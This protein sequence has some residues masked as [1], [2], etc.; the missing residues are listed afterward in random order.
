MT[1]KPQ[2]LHLAPASLLRP[3]D[4]DLSVRAR[5][6][7]DDSKKQTAGP[8]A[9]F[10]HLFEMWCTRIC[11][12]FT[13]SRS[14][15]A[16][17]D[18]PKARGCTSAYNSGMCEDSG[19]SIVHRQ[20]LSDLVREMKPKL[21]VEVGMANGVSS[22]A[23]LSSIGDGK[24]ISVDPNQSTHWKSNGLKA[25][26]EFASNHQLI[27]K[28]DYVALPELLS[29]GTSIDVAYVDGWHTFDYVLMDFFYID[30]MLRVGGIVGF[31]D[32]DMPA[33][34]KVLNFVTRHRK[35]VEVPLVPKAY[36]GRTAA[37]KLLRRIQNRQAQDRYFRK[38]ENWEPDWQFWNPF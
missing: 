21:V 8:F 27:E 13:K 1:K 26:A 16:Q 17:D 30:K 19:I 28:P 29:S 22:R 25:I 37:G 7:Q 36:S 32:C 12:G 24:L 5:F 10:P 33:I 35:Y 6:V 34:N 3:T 23:I 18:T 2:V 9:R 20:V 15:A 31:N 14:F 4:E 11:G 38:I